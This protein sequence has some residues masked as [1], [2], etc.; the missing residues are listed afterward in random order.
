MARS[1][2]LVSVTD[3]GTN[4][5][6]IMFDLN[7]TGVNTAVVFDI[8]DSAACSGNIFDYAATTTST[9]T[10]FEVTLA[11]AVGAILENYT[12]SGARTA[13]AMVVTHSGSGSNDI[14]AIVDSGTSSGHVWDINSTGNSTGD[15]MN[16]VLSSSKVAG[17]VFDINLGTGLASHALIIAAAGVRTEAIIKI[18]NSATDG[19][20]DDHVIDI[21]QIGLLDS[22][23][24]DITY[25]SGVSTG[26]AID[27]NMGSNVAGMAISIASAGTGASGEGSAIDITHTGA[28]T[29]GADVVNI[30]TSGVL[31][32]TSNALAIETTNGA[33]GSY[34]LYISAGNDMEGIHVDVG[35][36]TFDETLLVTGIATFTVAPVF[37]ASVEFANGVTSQIEATTGE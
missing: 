25:S 2:A 22:N 1:T 13:D 19:G 27:L 17:N 10:I 21:N 3:A 23:V 32:A 33:S 4:S 8:D 14:Y 12:L 26:N 11:N 20:A 9:G 16:I 28:L 5:G 18:D 31:S 35:T 7:R 24:L 36:V 34:A 15:V 37:S 30:T 6:G 29:G